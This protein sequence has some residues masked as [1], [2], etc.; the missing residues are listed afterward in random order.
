[1]KILFIS[2]TY[3]PVLGGVENQNYELSRGLQ[4]ITETR[5]IANKKGKKWLPIFLPLTFLRAFFLMTKYDTCL[6]GNGVLSPLGR[7][8]KFFHPQKKFCCVVHGLDITFA[9]RQSFLSKIYAKVN[10]PALR[11]LDKIFAVS[12]ATIEKAI[13]AGINR[14]KCFFIPNGVN[15]K[16][17]KQNYPRKE[18]SQLF[19]K[20]IENKK[21][22]LRLGRFVPHKGT[23]WFIENVMPKLEE[24]VVMI[25]AGGRVAENTVGDKDEF[26]DCEQAII[27][28]HLENRVRLLPSISQEKVK[29]L[30]NTAD[31][32]VSPN[33]K[34]PGSMEG[35]GMNV[36]EAGACDRVVLASDLEGLSN[37]INNGK[38]G[39]LVEPENAKQWVKKIEAI[40]KNGEKFREEFGKRIGVYVKENYNWGKI[41]QKYYN[42]M[43]S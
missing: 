42:E 13:G 8:L 43:N 29:I 25:A 16:D 40:F 10:I 17:F 22:I 27:D 34:V 38:N 28:N 36:I 20:N 19:G 7:F 39:I 35:F 32:V 5:I 14:E 15:V 41:C 18:L 23:S 21:V 2:H 37:A 30:F 24:D 26:L 11:K 6:L 1:M 31:L 9:D 3:P 4:K 33:I 12:N